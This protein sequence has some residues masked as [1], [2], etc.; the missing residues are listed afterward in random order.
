[1][2]NEANYIEASLTKMFISIQSLLPLIQ[3]IENSEIKHQLRTLICFCDITFINI[4]LTIHFQIKYLIPYYQ[5]IVIKIQAI[6]IVG[7]AKYEH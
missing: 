1:M 2:S 4:N 5:E 6:M 3:E 7:I